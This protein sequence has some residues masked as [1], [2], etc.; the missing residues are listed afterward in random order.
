MKTDK[1]DKLK[2]PTKPTLMDVDPKLYIM[3][4][5]GPPG[6]GK[7]FFVNG[8]GRVLF[9]STDRGTRTLKA[10]RTEVFSKKQLFKLIRKLE[11]IDCNEH[12]DFICIDHLDDVLG[13]L[14]EEVCDDL[15]IEDL[16]DTEWGKGWKRY[17]KIIIEVLN[18]LMRLGP[19]LIFI[20]HEEEK[21][22]ESRS[23]KITVTRPQ[24][25]KTPW[26]A[27]APKADL[28]GYCGFRTIKKGGERKQIRVLDTRPVEERYAKDRTKRKKPDEDSYERLDAEKFLA[29]FNVSSN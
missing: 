17:K 29:S 23:L 13:M 24:M 22:I 10:M 19:G 21:Q 9:I 16:G 11:S 18:R 26:K 1:K 7:T 14:E 4:F 28:I 12:Y 15:G 5:Y 25:A 6:V 20:C 3:L 8:L 2:L 27:I